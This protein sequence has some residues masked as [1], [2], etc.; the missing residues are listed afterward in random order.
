MKENTRQPTEENFCTSTHV[1]H[2]N[3]KVKEARM[4]GHTQNK[5]ALMKCAAQEVSTESNVRFNT[6]KPSGNCTYHPLLESIIPSF[7][8]KCIYRF[9]MILRINS[10]YFPERH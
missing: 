7:A 2:Q 5:R 1:H 10:D 8:H 9:H 4:L 6:L 3:A